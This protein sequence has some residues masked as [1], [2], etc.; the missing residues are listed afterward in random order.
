MA[1]QGGRGR[2]W[3]A[4]AVCQGA[5]RG[6]ER[7][8]VRCEG[9]DCAEL[10]P[11]A[12]HQEA[13]AALLRHLGTHDRAAA[14][15]PDPFDCRCAAEGHVWHRAV[16]VCSDRGVRLVVCD[17]RF[18]ALHLVEVCASC[19]GVMPRA[20]VL[21]PGPGLEGEAARRLR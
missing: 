19:A 3:S 5:V 16:S 9:G 12:G 6:A 11:F 13:L 15:V 10:G 21:R 2:L 18:L 1:G 17:E 4:T 20:K 7:T 14:E 8:V